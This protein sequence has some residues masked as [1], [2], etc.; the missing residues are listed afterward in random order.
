MLGEFV[1]ELYKSAGVLTLYEDYNFQNTLQGSPESVQCS[2]QIL[3]KYLF[4]FPALLRNKSPTFFQTPEF[5]F[6]Q[7]HQLP[8][9]FQNLMLPLSH[10]I[11]SRVEQTQILLLLKK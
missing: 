5:H 9:C 2:Y 4:H 10:S 1:C 6:E 11:S 7:Q 8:L 3:Y